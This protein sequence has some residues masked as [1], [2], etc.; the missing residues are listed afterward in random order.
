MRR[1]S[2]SEFARGHLLARI[3]QS[4]RIGESR[5]RKADLA[6]PLGELLGE[7]KLAARDALG[8]D[9]GAVIGRL[10]DHAVDE[11]VDRHL[12]V[13]RGEH[14]RAMRR[15]PAGAP[16][17]FAHRIF[18]GQLDLAGL[19]QMED[20]FR[21]HQLAETRRIDQLVGILLIKNAAAFG[22][23][24][25]GMRRGSPS[26]SFLG[27]GFFCACAALGAGFSGFFCAAPGEA[28]SAQSMAAA[29]ATDRN[30]KNR[31]AMATLSDCHTHNARA[32]NLEQQRFGGDLR[33]SKGRGRS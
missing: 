18:V 15:R 2:I 27:S 5:L 3:W 21:R 1:A 29:T 32:L 8:E 11:R 20:I 9:D 19:E 14:R 26:S 31:S 22:L 25:D 16:G 28:G 24:Q 33:L 7:I 12:A 4:V 23:D 6:R 30:R 13:Q 10:N 17:M